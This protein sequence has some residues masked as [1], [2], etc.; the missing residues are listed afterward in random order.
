MSGLGRPA[1]VSGGHNYPRS[2]CPGA[3]AMRPAESPFPTTSSSGVAGTQGPT[4]AGI[5]DIFHATAGRTSAHS[6]AQRLHHPASKRPTPTRETR[7]QPRSQDPRVLSYRSDTPATA[8]LRSGPGRCLSAV[9][10]PGPQAQASAI[11]RHSAAF[12]KAPH[13][14]RHL[15]STTLV[16]RQRRRS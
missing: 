2:L 4:T 13:A 12:H 1:Q 8:H 9:L 5:S 16:L 14:Q 11:A 6:P 10:A 3:S 7:H 15:L